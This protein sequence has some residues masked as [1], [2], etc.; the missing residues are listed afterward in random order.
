[1]EVSL[2]HVSRPSRTVAPILETLGRHACVVQ[3]STTRR[4]VPRIDDSEGVDVP[5]SV[6]DSTEQWVWSFM[7]MWFMLHVISVICLV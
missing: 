7:Y 5:C 6:T 2:L 3:V 4:P 1:M